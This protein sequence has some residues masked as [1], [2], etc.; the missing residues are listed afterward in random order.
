MWQRIKR[1]EVFWQPTNWQL[2]QTSHVFIASTI[3]LFSVVFEFSAWNGFWVVVL[4]AA[5]KD[6]I[7]DI[8]VEAAPLI[9]EIVDFIFY[10]FSALIT[11]LFLVW[12]KHG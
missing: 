7:F 1:R 12:W 4:F 2:A 5:I 9:G 11:T 10:V 6:F 8:I 3:V